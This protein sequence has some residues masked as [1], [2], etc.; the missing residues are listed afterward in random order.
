M[1]KHIPKK[2]V[3]TGRSYC[4]Q[5]CHTAGHRRHDHLEH[6]LS[7]TLSARDLYETET[8]DIKGT[9]AAREKWSTVW[10]VEKRVKYLRLTE[11]FETHLEQYTFLL[12]RPFPRQA[13]SFQDKYQKAISN[14]CEL[15]LAA[16]SRSSNQRGAFHRI[17]YETIFLK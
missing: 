16:K 5:I 7:Y 17:S 11:Q 8:V 13:G 1:Q 15:P 4:N 6:F 12:L 10:V 3:L 2:I 14:L 9:P